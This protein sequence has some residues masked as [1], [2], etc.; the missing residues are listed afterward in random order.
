MTLLTVTHLPT[1]SAHTLERPRAW[2]MY[3]RYARFR[4][5]YHQPTGIQVL[6]PIFR[7][8]SNTK[9]HTMSSR[10]RTNSI[11]TKLLVVGACAG[12]EMKSIILVWKH[13][14]ICKYSEPSSCARSSNTVY[15]GTQLGIHVLP[16]N[17]TFITYLTGWTDFTRYKLLTE[18]TCDP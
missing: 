8:M 11:Q 16:I 7:R 18:R 17:W 14:P 9:G 4:P 5:L 15:H 1:W 6:H 2:I 3:T 12:M 13:V 10:T